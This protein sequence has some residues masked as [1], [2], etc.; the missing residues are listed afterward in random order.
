MSHKILGIS[1]CGILLLAVIVC[2]VVYIIKKTKKSKTK[3]GF[4]AAQSPAVMTPTGAVYSG[5]GYGVVTDGWTQMPTDKIIEDINTYGVGSDGTPYL[6]GSTTEGLDMQYTKGNL[7]NNIRDEAQLTAGGMI[8]INQQA[9]IS[10]LM[11]GSANMSNAAYVTRAGSTPKQIELRP[12]GYVGVMDQSFVNELEKP[13]KL[14]ATNSAVMIPGYQ[15]NVDRL[16][17]TELPSHSATMN[18]NN[19]GRRI[20]TMPGTQLHADVNKLASVKGG[21]LRMTDSVTGQPTSIGLDPNA[22]GQAHEPQIVNQ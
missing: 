8:D 14:I 16:L 22:T 5:S 21:V 20:P 13:Q 19:H 18:R 15:I 1:V 6:E 17:A 4:F 9:G 10:K 12:G 7:I 11:D 2:L 3:E